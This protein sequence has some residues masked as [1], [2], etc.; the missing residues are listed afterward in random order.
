MGKLRRA[1]WAGVL[2]GVSSACTGANM[3]GLAR[4]FMKPEERELAP[5]VVSLIQGGDRDGFKQVSTPGLYK[6]MSDSLWALL[7]TQIKGVNPDS[8]RVLSVSVMVPFHGVRTTAETLEG[9]VPDGWVDVYVGTRGGRVSGF[10]ARRQAESTVEENAFGHAPFRASQVPMALWALATIVLALTAAVRVVRSPMKRRWLW[11]PLS[12]LI[13]GRVSL[14][15]TTGAL[16][17]SPLFLSLSPFMW[18]KGGPAAPWVLTVGLPAGALIAWHK[19]SMARR[20]AGPE[21][22]PVEL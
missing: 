21:A 4:R 7:A 22:P 3:S 10:G 20:A 18:L 14:N 17:A 13:V 6:Q 15:W 5:K 16:T 19:A 1:A 2:V 11:A 9:R 12:L 8:M